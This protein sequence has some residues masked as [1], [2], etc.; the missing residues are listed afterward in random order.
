MKML[1]SVNKQVVRLFVLTYMSIL[2]FTGP[3]QVMAQLKITYP[4]SRMIL[5]RDAANRAT[6]QVA[7]SYSLALDR[8]EARAV[9]RVAG[10]GTTTNWATL[11]TNPQNGQFTG[12]MPVLGGWYKIQV[13]GILNGSIVAQDS[14]DRFGVGEVFAIIG[15]SNAQGSSCII[16]GVD[17][18]PT[19][20][21]ATDDR[22]TV[23]AVDQS[24]PVYDQYLS[25]AD[26]RYLPG[27]AFAQLM[28]RNGSSPFAREA[29]LWGRMGDQLVQQINVPVLIY[30]AGFGGSTMQQTY[31]SAYDIPFQHSFVRYAIRMPFVNVR[32]LMNLYVTSTGIRAILVQHGENDR[33]NSENEIFQY[34]AGVIDKARAEFSKSDLGYIVSISSYVGGRFDNVRS[35]QSRIINQANYRTFQGPDLDNINTFDDRPD[36][37]HFSPTGQVK[38]GNMWAEA[39]KNQYANCTPYPAQQQPLASIACAPGNQL[40]L[41]QPASYQYNWDIGSNAQSL[42]VDAGTYAA[43]LKDAQNQIFFPPAVVVPATVRPAPPTIGTASGIFDICRTTGLTLTSSYNGLN[44]WSTGVTSASILVN[45]PGQYT[46]QAR[47]PAYGCLSDVVS[48]QIGVA[49]VTLSLAMQT[50]RRV[51]A[52]NDTVTFRLLVRNWGECDAGSVTL[53]NRLPPN[54][55]VVSAIGPLSV[56]GGV[57]SG[58]WPNVL[59]GNEISQSYVA[60]LTAAGTYRSSAELIASASTEL[61]AT[62]GNGT[63]NGETDEATADLRTTVFSASLFESPNPNQG[64]L[65][66]VLSGQPTPEPNKA[67][68]SLQLL[69]AQQ[70]MAVSQTVGVTVVVSNAG[71]QVA[72]NVGAAVTLPTGMQFWGSSSGMSASG[73]VV[74]GTVAQIPVGQSATLT[75]TMKATGSGTRNLPAQITSVG[76]SDPD[77]VPN[78]G[79]TNGEDDTAVVTLRVIE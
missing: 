12:T 50:S 72:T 33:G 52:V 6:V 73:A 65:P 53:A 4:I 24:T 21:G 30:N 25:T 67:D 48:K 22:V 66:P 7:G 40:I 10:Q 28:T 79:Y 35:A 56:A 49:R 11:Q 13:R 15:H 76:Q 47:H 54:V 42:T 75:F 68:L 69:L 3:T 43:R 18:C 20:A 74:S 71:G 61:G 37:L 31:W 51:V 44:T 32:N 39:I 62:P 29:W 5:Q 14:V 77:S 58:T 34:Y 8:I 36:G 64:P 19:I 9:T 23:V 38:A 17:K 59:A 78:N 2:G 41:S 26:T 57:V 70:V 63:G 1:L 55:S 45:A 27:L 16:N 60:R 46:V